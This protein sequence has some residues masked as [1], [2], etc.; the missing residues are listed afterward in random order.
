MQLKANDYEF[1]DVIKIIREW[2]EMT[3]KEFAKLVGMSYGTIT[4]YEN[5]QRNGSFMAFV[6]ICKKNNVEIILKKK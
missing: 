6:E 4:K 5:G 1:R 2:N 3:Q